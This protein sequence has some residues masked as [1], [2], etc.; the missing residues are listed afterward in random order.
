MQFVTFTLNVSVCTFLK[1][2]DSSLSH[3]VDFK[4]KE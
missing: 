2:L 3:H 4:S 1:F